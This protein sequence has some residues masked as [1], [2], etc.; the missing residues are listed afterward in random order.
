[1]TAPKR[2]WVAY[3]E[4]WGLLAK[5]NPKATVRS[6]IRHAIGWAVAGVATFWALVYWK[7]GSIDYWP[8]K[9]IGF[10]ALFGCV[11]GLMEW[12]IDDSD[13]R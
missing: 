11:G 1:M 7:D 3:G 6:L 13:D 5:T 10:A 2:R 12:Q 4:P 8:A 9:S